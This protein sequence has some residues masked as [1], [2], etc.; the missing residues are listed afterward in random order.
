MKFIASI[1]A[2]FLAFS[3]LFSQTTF[4]WSGTYGGTGTNRTYTTNLSSIK[5]AL[6]D[7]CL[8]TPL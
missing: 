7:L 8:N 5:K 4:P 1:T 3:C 6:I 2:I